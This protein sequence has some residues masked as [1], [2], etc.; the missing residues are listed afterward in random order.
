VSPRKA[1]K[2]ADELANRLIGKRVGFRRY[3]EEICLRPANGGWVWLVRFEWHVTVGG[4][5]GIPDQFIVVVLMD[6]AAV[7][8]KV[9]DGVFGDEAFGDRPGQAKQPQP[10]RH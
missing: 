9:R 3:L 1:I 7:Q 8:P 10:N 5:T 4:E 2:A 6:G